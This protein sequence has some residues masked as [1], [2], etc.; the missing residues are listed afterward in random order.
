MIHKRRKVTKIDGYKEKAEK[1]EHTRILG[2]LVENPHGNL[3]EIQRKLCST[4]KRNLEVV[5]T[6]KLG[7]APIGAGRTPIGA[8]E[9]TTPSAIQ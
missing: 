8:P 7:R 3:E 5:R 6:A 4:P 1:C 2:A 9:R